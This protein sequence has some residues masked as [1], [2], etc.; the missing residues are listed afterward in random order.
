MYASVYRVRTR[1]SIEL[2][3]EGPQSFSLEWLI[4]VVCG[5]LG[6][7]LSIY[8]YSVLCYVFQVPVRIAGR[9]RHDQ[10][11]HEEFLYIMILGCV[12]WIDM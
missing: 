8:A 12:L 4:C 7:S 2:G 11:T 9:R 1:G 10:Y 6:N 5:I 3:P